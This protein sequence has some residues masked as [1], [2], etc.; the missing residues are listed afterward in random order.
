MELSKHPTHYLLN[1]KDLE[2]GRILYDE[3]SMLTNK[4]IDWLGK[5]DIRPD[6]III[7]SKGSTM[8]IAIVD[9][10]YKSSFISGNLSRI[11]VNPHKYN[12]YV[13]YEFLQSEIGMKMLKGIQTGTTINLL[14]TSQLERLE[15]PLLDLEI[16]NEFGDEIKSNK[17]EYERML[18]ETIMKFENKRNKIKQKMEEC[19]SK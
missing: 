9:N 11:R 3:S 17:L 16:M 1:V 15:V 13:L 2:N 18:D 4:K 19:I 10:E 6:D 7:T 8:K 14:N 5:Y 12:A